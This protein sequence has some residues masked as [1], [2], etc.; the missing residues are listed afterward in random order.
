[1]DKGENMKIISTYNSITQNGKLKQKTGQYAFVIFRLLFFIGMI[2]ITLYPILIMV[3]R[4]FRTPE[5]MLNPTV[6]WLPQHF[7]IKNFKII[8]EIIDYKSTAILTARI[9]IISTLFTMVSC[10]MTGYALGRYKMR[11]KVILMTFAILTIVVPL[12]SYLIPIFFKFRFFDFFG[13]GKLI[14]L[15]TGND[16]V[17]RLSESEI[18]YYILAIFGMGIRSG[19]FILLFYQNFKGMPKELEDAARIDGCNEFKVFT[20]VMLPNASAPF[21]VTLILSLVWYWNDTVYDTILMRKTQLL[22]VKVADLKALVNASFMG[23]QKFGIEKNGVSETVLYFAAAILFIIPP[24]ILYL[25]VQRFFMQ[26]V[27]RSGIVG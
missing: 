18:S 17:I 6:I 2:Y 25:I 21:L 3:S 23:L 20:R 10:S 15:F 4:A 7:T 13:V 1:M 14:G 8:A 5:D 26:S 22:A 24:L 11:G 27:E 12:Q 19:L 9:A 16:V